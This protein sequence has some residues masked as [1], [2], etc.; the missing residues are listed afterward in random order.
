MSDRFEQ[1]GRNYSAPELANS[2]PGA[3]KTDFVRH[4][5]AALGTW[6]ATAPAGARLQPSFDQ[7]NRGDDACIPFEP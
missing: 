5:G 7:T 1:C 3:R 4:R 2:P 6:G